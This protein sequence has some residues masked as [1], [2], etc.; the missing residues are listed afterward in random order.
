LRQIEDVAGSNTFTNLQAD[1]C[2]ELLKGSASLL[3]LRTSSVFQSFLG[4]TSA[5][6]GEPKDLV[7]MDAFLEV[8]ALMARFLDQLLNSADV[9]S[10]RSMFPTV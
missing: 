9:Q 8:Y 4:Y 6:K 7:R 3:V 5:M 1:L 10:Q 2:A